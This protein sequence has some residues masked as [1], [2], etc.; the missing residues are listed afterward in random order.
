MKFTDKLTILM[1]ERSINKKTV[2]D[3]SDIPYTTIDGFFKKGYENIKLSNLKKLAEFFDVSIDFL[4]DDET[5]FDEYHR[6]LIQSTER[7]MINKYRVL[8]QEGKYAVDAMLDAHYIR[9]TKPAQEEDELDFIE[10]PYFEDKAAA[11][12]GYMLDDGRCEMLKVQ[13]TRKAERADFI[14]TVSGSSME[15]D[16]FDGENVLVH[17]QPDVYVGEVGIFIVNGNGYIKQKG[18]DRLISLNKKYR[19]IF[20]G[21]YDNVRCVGKVVGK[22]DESEV[23]N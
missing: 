16:Y 2:S 1:A 8:D 6:S 20:I 10:I 17:S 11:G 4:A 12:S 9:V 23:L 22:L 13:R 3:G 18:A 5:D 21:E 19:D 7:V 14:V 15:P